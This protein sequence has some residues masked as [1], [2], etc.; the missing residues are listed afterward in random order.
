MTK[1]W[2][3]VLLSGLALAVLLVVGLGFVYMVIPQKDAFG[4]MGWRHET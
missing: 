4:N 3:R 1:R 2:M